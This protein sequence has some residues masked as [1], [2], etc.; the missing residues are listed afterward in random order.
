MIPAAKSGSASSRF[1]CFPAGP[2]EGTG[3]E[4]RGKNMR[5]L[6]KNARV[7]DGTGSEPYQADIL[8]EEDRIA[9]IAPKI[10]LPAD[11]V[12]D[13]TG[14]SVSSGFIDAHSHND[15][16]AIKKEP[17]PYFRPFLLQGI[18]TF[19]AGNCGISEIGFEKGND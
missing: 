11:N 15:W 6:L 19:I 17:L 16:F 5:Q 9:M 2:G 18:T 14:K 13:L 4:E 10:D 1:F 8:L 12:I 7:Y 3:K